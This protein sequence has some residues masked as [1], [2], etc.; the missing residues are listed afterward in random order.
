MD[1]HKF[2]GGRR[3]GHT[4]RDALAYSVDEAAQLI[5]VSRRTIYELIAQRR[6]KSIKLRGRRLITR[7]ALEQLLADAENEL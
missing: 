7:T 2:G 5:G 4:R 1:T 6:L 3:R